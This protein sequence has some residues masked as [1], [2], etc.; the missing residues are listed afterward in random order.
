MRLRD[1]QDLGGLLEDVRIAEV[2]FPVVG[3]KVREAPD[4]SSDGDTGRR[5]ALAE[6]RACGAGSK[7]VLSLILGQGPCRLAQKLGENLGNLKDRLIV[8]LSLIHI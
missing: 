5:T 4:E 1:V 3:G 2:C 8:Q 7:L 6:T